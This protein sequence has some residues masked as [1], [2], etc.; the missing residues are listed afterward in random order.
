M[1][2]ASRL[3]YFFVVPDYLEIDLG[4]R[5]IASATP[6]YVKSWPSCA[7]G[8]I[9]ELT[10]RGIDMAVRGLSNVLLPDSYPS[11]IGGTEIGNEAGLRMRN[12]ASVMSPYR[13]PKLAVSFGLGRNFR[14]P[15]VASTIENI[16]GLDNRKYLLIKFRRR[17]KIKTVEE[18]LDR[19]SDFGLN[20]LECD[21]P[22]ATEIRGRVATWF[23]DSVDGIIVKEVDCAND[24]AQWYLAVI[25]FS[26]ISVE[27]LGNSGLDSVHIA[28]SI[29]TRPN[30]RPF[31]T[32]NR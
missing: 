30:F 2:L 5:D 13:L 27:L 18:L 1:L 15:T 12:D 24:V 29:D 21:V 3:S 10:G 20:P 17:P 32:S 26:A 7:M 31:W 28:A 23:S 6:Y 16:D 25:A 19:M 8:G 14:R 22:V 11:P 9:I 4:A